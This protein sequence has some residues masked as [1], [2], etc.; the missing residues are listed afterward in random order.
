MRTSI[1]IDDELIAKGLAYTGLKT[2]RT[3][4]NYAL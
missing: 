3:L 1:G 4:L 2:K